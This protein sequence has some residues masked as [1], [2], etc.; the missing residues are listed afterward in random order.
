[1]NFPFYKKIKVIFLKEK[2]LSIVFI[3]INIAN[4]DMWFKKLGK[5]KNFFLNDPLYSHTMDDHELYHK[6]F[7]DNSLDIFL[8]KKW[9]I[10]K[11]T[12]GL[13]FSGED[14]TYSWVYWSLILI[15]ACC[16]IFYKSSD[17]KNPMNLAWMGA[18]IIGF[19]L[20]LYSTWN[21]RSMFEPRYYTSLAVLII[22]GLFYLSSKLMK[23]KIGWVVTGLWLIVVIAILKNNSNVIFPIKKSVVD[24]YAKFAEL[25][26]G[27]LIANYWHVYKVNAI[28]P[29]N[30]T[31]V[32]IHNDAQR[33]KHMIEEVLD[34]PIIYV[35]KNDYLDMEKPMPD[36]IIQFERVLVKIEKDERKID[37]L[38]FGI[39]TKAK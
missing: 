21:Y 31:G 22:A 35:I 3:G 25:P 29:Y 2:N 17:I 12:T 27:G 11:L 37:E 8:Q 5:Y 1:L 16:L 34:K 4:L 36:T 7:L 19:I 20:L 33:N 13:N 6:T 23:L 39:Y 24:K 14:T 30:L 28:A 9:M 10:E 26:D 15:F 32:P 18:T 38:I